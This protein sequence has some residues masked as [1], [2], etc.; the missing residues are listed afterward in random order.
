MDAAQAEWDY[1]CFESEAVERVDHPCYCSNLIYTVN[2]ATYTAMIYHVFSIDLA[3]I[4]VF[5]VPII[6]CPFMG[7]F[8]L[9]ISLQFHNK[10]DHCL[11]S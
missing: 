10:L 4:I 9:L 6:N 11:Q 8:S 1:F 3:T 5:T 2:E 7:L